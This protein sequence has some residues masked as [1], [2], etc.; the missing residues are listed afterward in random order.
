MEIV[1]YIAYVSL[2]LLAIAWTLNVRLNPDTDVPGILRA[3]YFVLC[4]SFIPA[5]DMNMLHALWMAPFG[6]FFAKIIAPPLVTIPVLSV[7]FIV[8]ADAF[9]RFARIGLP[10]PEDQEATEG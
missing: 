10:V 4:V 5:L 3:V 2:I 6:C 9:A 1:G 7:P 8:T